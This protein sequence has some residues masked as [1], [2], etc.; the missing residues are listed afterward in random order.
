MRKLFAIIFVRALLVVPDVSAETEA[1][2]E[3]FAIVATNAQKTVLLSITPSNV[4]HNVIVELKCLR[5]TGSAC[6]LPSRTTTTNVTQTSSLLIQGE[7]LS[8]FEKN[9]I[10]E[11]RSGNDILGTNLFT[12]VD[13]NML[14]FAQARILAEQAIDGIVE[15]DGEHPSVRLN[16]TDDEYVIT[17]EN[18]PDVD[19]LK[20]DFSARIR[21]G[22]RNGAIIDIES[23]P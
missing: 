23:S 17:F 2:I 4:S 16:D 7:A 11:V 10:V 21:V 6:F 12:V 9:M 20:G 18:T 14:S 15:P 8:A 3:S 5:A 13:T 1:S 19:A 22:S